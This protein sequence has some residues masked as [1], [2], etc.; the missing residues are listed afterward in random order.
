MVL[1]PQTSLS[2][3]APGSLSWRRDSNQGQCLLEHPKKHREP[4]TG[5]TPRMLEKVKRLQRTPGARATTGE[6]CK[7]G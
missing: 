3:P 5:R 2:L 7:G 1:A 6:A 4:R